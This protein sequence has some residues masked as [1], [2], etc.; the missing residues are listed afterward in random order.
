[1]IQ[2]GYNTLNERDF[3]AAFLKEDCEEGK[4][5]LTISQKDAMLLN[6]FKEI[7]NNKEDGYYV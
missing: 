6:I 7:Q 4:N 2:S 3:I 1:M 5:Q